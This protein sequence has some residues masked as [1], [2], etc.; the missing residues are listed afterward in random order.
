MERVERIRLP[1]ISARWLLLLA[2]FCRYGNHP[3]FYGFLLAVL[4]MQKKAH[5]VLLDAS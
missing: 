1:A 2:L 5:G 4:V 3:K